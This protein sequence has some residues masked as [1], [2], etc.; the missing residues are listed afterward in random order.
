VALRAIELKVFFGG[1]KK[2]HNSII[3]NKLN[4]ISNRIK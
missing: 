3:D 2:G 1:G 4:T